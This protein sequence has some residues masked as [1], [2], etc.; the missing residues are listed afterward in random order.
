MDSEAGA[1]S[2][3]WI[4]VPFPLAEQQLQDESALASNII[5]F[6]DPFVRHPA[7]LPPMRVPVEHDP[8]VH[9]I[10]LR[11][12]HHNAANSPQTV[13]HGAHLLIPTATHAPNDYIHSSHY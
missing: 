7:H 3:F 13:T 11:D 2:H 10:L 4:D 12:T 8:L 9:L 6:A 5:P 1:G